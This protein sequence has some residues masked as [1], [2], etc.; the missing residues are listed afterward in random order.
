MQNQLTEAAELERA[1]QNEKV[2]SIRSN[3]LILKQVKSL[4]KSG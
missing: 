2:M 4:N 1:S 3:S